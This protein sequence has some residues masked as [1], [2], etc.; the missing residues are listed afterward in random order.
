MICELFRT[1]K[2]AIGYEAPLN[3]REEIQ[4]GPGEIHGGAVGG[5]PP[6]TLVQTLLRL[7]PEAAGSVSSPREPVKLQISILREGKRFLPRFDT[8]DECPDLQTL[9]QIIMEHYSG[10]Y[11]SNLRIQVLLSDGLQPVA[12]DDE[13]MLALRSI[14][15]T[16][17]MDGDMKVIVEFE[18]A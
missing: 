1:V 14:Q 3:S 11:L 7:R 17:W 2:A 8:P 6:E 4:C 18:E 5:E 10:C 15:S 9:Y 16:D 13:W 12:S